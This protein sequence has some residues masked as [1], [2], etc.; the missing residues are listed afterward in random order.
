MSKTRNYLC[1]HGHFYQ[2]P[3]E[4][5]WLDTVEEQPSAAPYHDWNERVTAE[6]YASNGAARILDERNRI[7][8]IVNNY[9]DISFNFGPTL[10]SWLATERPDVYRAVLAADARSAAAR[11]GHGN[12]IAQ[13]YNHVIMPL[14]TLRDKRTQVRWGIADFVHRFGR[15][16]AGMW[17][18]ETAVDRET[19][20]VLAEHGIR[21]V[22]LAQHQAEA[23]RPRGSSDWAETAG[24]DID[25]TRPYHCP[26]DEGRALSVLF[27]DGPISRALAFEGLLRSGARMLERIRQGFSESR[28]WPQLLLLATDGETF[29]HHNRFGEMALAWAID[30]LKRDGDIV[31]TNPAAFLAEHPPEWEVRV[32]DETSWS[33]SHGVERW[34][35]DC[36]CTTGAGG[37]GW[38]QAWRAPLRRALEWLRQEI[39]EIF[40]GS[41]L[42]QDPWAA[43][44]AYIAVLMDNGDEVRGSF[45]KQHFRPR[46]PH[47]Q[48]AWQALEMEHC[49]QLMFTSCAWFFDEVSRIETRQVLAYAARAIQLA[50][51]FQRELEGR[52]LELLAEA[53][54]NLADEHD[55]ARV[56]ERYVR[57]LR[58]TRERVVAHT[59]T[60]LLIGPR[61]AE[62]PRS[63]Y[64]FDVEFDDLVQ[65]RAGAAAVA[66]GRLRVSC[67]RTG[68]GGEA[69][70]C[71]IHYGGVD[72]HCAV[73]GSSSEE[74]YEKARDEIL[75]HFRA[76]SLTAVVRSVDNFFGADYRTLRDLFHEE[77]KRVLY[78][79]SDE[80]LRRSEASYRRLYEENRQLM[81][82]ARQIGVPV[83]R[84][85]RQASSFVLGIELRRALE[86]PLEPELFERLDDI[87]EQIAT[88][89]ATVD[90]QWL[91]WRLKARLEEAMKAAAQKPEAPELWARVE[92]LLDAAA[93]LD[94]AVDL[95]GTQNE[96]Y[97]LAKGLSGTAAGW[98]AR[99]GER[100]G[101]DA[102][103]LS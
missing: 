28:G 36:G 67:R 103:I 42:F 55:G 62:P 92:R 9:E 100:L 57:P 25:P 58:V 60:Q 69:A 30:R 94:V 52:F 93:A 47:P 97:G 59:A 37:V 88:W 101:F 86:G 53:P 16:P 65:E 54:S 99:L 18:A 91:A 23:V 32:R 61:A 10:A 39:D 89:E 70:F 98:I 17:L 75:D 8:E 31:V 50:Q 14:A 87:I 80:T 74:E 15:R 64:C 33:C 68:E 49:A 43:R 72:F 29:G 40:E 34:R 85:F 24:D 79:V 26:L 27:Y 45:A 78:E 48:R 7:I 46:L 102:G 41:G 95:S 22:I 21:Y 35:S 66:V 56:Y 84:S 12:A 73:R 76:Y 63:V 83:L 82:F 1:I 11:G 20:N 5:P 90:T 71:A 81:D 4:N 44:D 19:L 3:R 96:F 51:S 77:R 13:V 2:P 38:S 6:C